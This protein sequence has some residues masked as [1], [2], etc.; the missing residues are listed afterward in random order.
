MWK[1]YVE[2]GIKCV[3][4]ES[5]YWIYPNQDISSAFFL[6]GSNYVGANQKDTVSALW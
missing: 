4:S 1:T 6:R 2:M 3:E 5:V